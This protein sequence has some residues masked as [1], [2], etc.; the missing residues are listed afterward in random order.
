MSSYVKRRIPKDVLNVFRVYC[1]VSDS[2]KWYK[3]RA[4]RTH[5]RETSPASEV[6]ARYRLMHDRDKVHLLKF[7][8]MVASVVGPIFR[9]DLDIGRESV[10]TTDLARIPAVSPPDGKPLVSDAHIRHKH[11]TNFHAKIL[12]SLASFYSPLQQVPSFRQAQKVHEWY[13]RL[14]ENTPVMFFLQQKHRLLSETSVAQINKP[15]DDLRHRISALGRS[16]APHRTYHLADIQPDRI[17]L[18]APDGDPLASK[19]EALHS[20]E[21]VDA[22][23]PVSPA[24]AGNLD[25]YQRM[26][27]YSPGTDVRQVYPYDML[28][29][30]FYTVT[31]EAPIIEH[32]HL[33]LLELL[34]T[35]E[36]ELVGARLSLHDPY[37]SGFFALDWTTQTHHPHHPF[38]PAFK[39]LGQMG[40]T[41]AEQTP[42]HIYLFRE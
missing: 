40:L 26:K 8:P 15:L 9:G 31:I 29:T 3:D 23:G 41:T 27:Q 21:I 28:Y 19:L 33:K 5:F 42:S 1:R 18:A 25:M 36:F 12:E 22:N 38:V 39:H 10:S 24:L 37:L 17:R 35:D 4:V 34:E 16:I 6:L 20:V 7:L 14:L 2:Q 32:N 30:T 13:R 11:M